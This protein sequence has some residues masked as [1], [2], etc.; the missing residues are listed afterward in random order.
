MTLEIR[1]LSPFRIAALSAVSHGLFGLAMSLMMYVVV[2]ALPLAHLPP[3]VLNLNRVFSIVSTFY[4]LALA[5]WG[6]LGGLSFAMLYNSIARLIGG[7]TMEVSVHR[8][9]DDEPRR[10]EPQ[11]PQYPLTTDSTS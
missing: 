7:V 6:W 11:G 5:A 3:E 2:R 9:H 8:R 4:P 1:R 10:P